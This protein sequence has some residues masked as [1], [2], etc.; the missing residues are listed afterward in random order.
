MIKLTADIIFKA[1]A[2]SVFP[3]ILFLMLLSS[4]HNDQKD[5]DM[6]T[7]KNSL[8]V[9]RGTDVTIIYSENGKVRGRLFAK[10][11]IHNTQAKPPYMD[12]SKGLKIEMFDDSLK[13]TS[14]LTARYGRYYETRK[15]VLIRD[16]VVFVNVRGERLDTQELVWNQ[17]AQKFFTE[18]PVRITT[19][20]QVLYGDGLEANQDFSDYQISNP[21]STVRVQKNELP[22]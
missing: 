1:I 11:Y 15:N 22:R 13:V 9:D 20:T 8:Q 16:S 7:G 10:E 17:S 19:P 6:L 5:I 21:R 14:T 4:C 18:K 2:R 3:G 12:M